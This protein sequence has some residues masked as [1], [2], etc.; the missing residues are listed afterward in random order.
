M[1]TTR[2]ET[3]ALTVSALVAFA[4]NSLLCRQ[5]L[6]RASIDAASFSTIRLISGSAALVLIALATGRGS[7]AGKGTWTSAA[8]LFLYAVPFSFAYLSLGAGTGALILF[9]AVQATMLGAALASGE[10]MSAAQWTGLVMALGGLVGLVLPGLSAPSPVGCALMATAGIAWGIY[11]LRGRGAADPLSATAGNFLRSVPLAV[12]VSVL[13]SSRAHVSRE[14]AL[15]AVV[16]GSLTSG[17]GYVLWYAALAG[18]SAARAATVQLAVPVLAAIGGVVFLTEQVTL[19]LLLSATLILGGVALAVTR[20]ELHRRQPLP[21]EA[22]HR[23]E[24]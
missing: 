23:Q 13:A 12:A 17:C 14:G 20:R 6:G 16:S 21:G 15:L 22:S 9:G 7:V 24:P 4:A 10:R 5:A 19:R 2:A 3:L 11:S 1:T 8:L 18:L